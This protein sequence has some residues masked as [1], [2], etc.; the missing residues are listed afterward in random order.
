MTKVQVRFD[1][2]EPPDE[3]Q[4]EKLAVAH[5]IYGI[6]RLKF[7]NDLLGVTVD[8]DA[9][10]MARGDVEAALTGRGLPLRA[11]TA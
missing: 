3:K 2:A 8:Y 11:K 1:L 7:D 10:R 4:L 6:L 9:S 5:S